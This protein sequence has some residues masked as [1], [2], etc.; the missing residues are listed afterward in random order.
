MG[1]WLDAGELEAVA[2]LEKG[3]PLDKLFSVFKKNNQENSKHKR[4]E[5]GNVFIVPALLDRNSIRE[6]YALAPKNS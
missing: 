5:P 1:I 6:I 4:P 2:K 3:G